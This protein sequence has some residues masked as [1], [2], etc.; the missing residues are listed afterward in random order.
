VEELGIALLNSIAFANLVFWTLQLQGSFAL[1]WL[2]YFVTLS[3]GIG[4]LPGLQTAV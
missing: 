2:T 4:E 1:F 3:T